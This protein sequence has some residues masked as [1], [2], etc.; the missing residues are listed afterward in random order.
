MVP[1]RRALPI[2][3]KKPFLQKSIGTSTS[4]APGKMLESSWRDARRYRRNLSLSKLTMPLL[5]AEELIVGRKVSTKERGATDAA[6]EIL[7]T[8]KNQ[9]L[10]AQMAKLLFESD[11]REKARADA[12]EQHRRANAENREQAGLRLQVASLK[13]QLQAKQ[14]TIASLK[15]ENEKEI[16]TLKHQ[17]AGRDQASNDL[18]CLIHEG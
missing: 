13:E 6:L 14:D 1:G 5:W 18:A 15:A 9:N 7:K 17:I 16:E 10:K 2:V 12:R 3:E 4:K 11:G 8:T